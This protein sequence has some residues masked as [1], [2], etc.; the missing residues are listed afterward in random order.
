MSK[1]S[2]VRKAGRKKRLA[3]IK[4]GLRPMTECLTAEYRTWMGIIQRCTNKN[5]CNYRYY[6]G[7]GIRICARW[8]FSYGHFLSDMGRKPS[9]DLEIDR[10]NNS[11]DYEPSNCRWATRSRNSRNTRRTRRISWGGKEMSLSDWADKF[12][13]PHYIVRHRL[14]RGWSVADALTVKRGK[15]ERRNK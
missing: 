15:Y 1:E 4:A 14:D 11:G 8:L 7:R 13:I 9:D 10:I 2:A 6:G 12:G 3:D 5:N